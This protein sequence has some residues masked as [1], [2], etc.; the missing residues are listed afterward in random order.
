MPRSVAA[1]VLWITCIQPIASA[2]DLRGTLTDETANPLA[3]ATVYIYWLAPQQGPLNLPPVYADWGKKALTD[4]S[5]K[6][7]IENVEPGM[8]YSLVVVADGYAPSQIERLDINSEVDAK[9][10]QM[11]QQRAEKEHAIAGRVLDEKGEPIWGA[12][13]RSVGIRTGN[14][15]GSGQM[16]GV[17]R[18]TVTNPKGE[19][20]IT[21]ENTDAEIAVRI[22]G[23][24]FAAMA[25]DFQR[26][27]GGSV[28]YKLT[29]GATIR[30]KLIKDGN[31]VPKITVG[32]MLT[33]RSFEHMTLERE[34]IT[35]DEGIFVFE[36]VAANDEYHVYTK[37]KSA[38]E[39]GAMK[40]TNI[41]TPNDNQAIELGDVALEPALVLAGKVQAGE[42]QALPRRVRLTLNRERAKDSISATTDA[43]GKFKLTGIPA[44]EPIA[45]QVRAQNH[46]LSRENFSLDPLNTWRLMGIVDENIEDLEILLEPGSAPPSPDQDTSEDTSEKR[47]EL[48]SK[49]IRGVNPEPK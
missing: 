46:Y 5:G 1:V 4:A 9:L 35:N 13:V 17:D 38:G 14:Y 34:A 19:F 42:G 47:K 33:D 16:E 29:A 21:T 7:V 3:N 45:L 36:H 11:P 41:K 44:S 24:G 6:F 12:E 18:L 25:I 30:G 48:E 23:P 39:Q 22:G 32:A 43:E 15:T 26:P 40:L 49:R 20:V 8:A 28:D 27:G 37:M 2:T 10:I 31:P